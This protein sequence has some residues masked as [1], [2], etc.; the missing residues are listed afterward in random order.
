MKLRT[1][2]L[3]TLT[4]IALISCKKETPGCTDPVASNY[5][6]AATEDNGTCQYIGNVVF[7]VNQPMNYVDVTLGEATKTITGYYPSGDVTCTSVGCAHFTLPSG[8]Y[9]FTA[10]EQGTFNYYTSTVI[11][12][13][14]GCNKVLLY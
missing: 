2:F 13:K 14:G 7:W 12:P 1:L 5:S 10:E 6:S 3:M 8:V 9:T 11:V 4:A